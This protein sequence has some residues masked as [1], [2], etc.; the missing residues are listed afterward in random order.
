LFLLILDHITAEQYHLFS[1]LSIV[2]GVYQG[3]ILMYIP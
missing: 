2:Q 1:I 3:V